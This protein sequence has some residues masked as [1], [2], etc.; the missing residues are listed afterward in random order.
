MRRKAIAGSE[1]ARKKL[2]FKQIFK[3]LMAGKF[4]TYEMLKE[5]L[6]PKSVKFLD[7][8][9]QKLRKAEGVELV[10]ILPDQTTKGGVYFRLYRP[11]TVF[12]PNMKCYPNSYQPQFDETWMVVGLGAVWP[13]RDFEGKPTYKRESPELPEFLRDKVFDFLKKATGRRYKGEEIFR[14]DPSEPERN[15][16]IVAYN[17]NLVRMYNALIGNPGLAERAEEIAALIGERDKK[18]NAIFKEY[19]T[20]IGPL[21]NSL[22]KMMEEV[23]NARNT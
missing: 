10:D 14:L 12:F 16:E 23:A 18:V 13:R 1:N 8:A 20:R 2:D 3:M 11:A 5:A 4:I 6:H 17:A 15:K 19:G 21:T 22:D 7:F 9:E